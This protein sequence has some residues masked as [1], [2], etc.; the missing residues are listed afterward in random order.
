MD[1]GD[2]ESA[3]ATRRA[4]SARYKTL[5][6]DD[7]RRNREETTVSIRKEKRAEN[8][9]KKRFGGM[10]PAVDSY[11]NL[12]LQ[13]WQGANP[14][15]LVAG[16]LSD[17]PSLQLQAVTQFRKLL[18]IERSP[19]I[20]EVIAAG[21]VPRFV[22]LLQCADNPALQFEAA[23][24]LTNIASGTS[25]HTREVIS[26]GAVPIFVQLLLSSNDDV[27]EQAV[28]A[29]GNIAGDSPEC[30][31][32]VLNHGA[33]L[34]LL[35]QLNPNS[36]MSMLRNATWTLSNLCRGKPQPR[37]DF[38]SPALPKLAQL[39]FSNDEEVLADGCWALSYLSDGPNEK[40]QAVLDTGICPRIV[41]L[42]GQPHASVQTPALRTAG[43]IVTGDD[44]QTQA[45]IN[46]G[47][48]AKLLKLLSSSKKGIRKEACWTISNITAGTREQIQATI[49]A[50]VV[51]PL[52]Q[53][54]S[55]A[56]FD[57]KKEAAWSISNATSGGTPEQIAYLVKQGCIKPLCDLLTVQDARLIT[58]ALEGIENILK[59]GEQEAGSNAALG[60][61]NPYTAFVDEAEGLD[62]LEALQSHQNEDVYKKAV[63]ILET[64][65][66]I[67]DDE[68]GALAPQVDAQ[69]GFTFAQQQ[70]NAQQGGF[71]FG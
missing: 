7:A 27:R 23:W 29:L 41:E 18:S 62:K 43:N 48:L 67:E 66:G 8:V 10:P 33:L 37:W 52:V 71:Q 65:F 59:A 6:K 49:D 55:T 5:D 39:V 31:D 34:P 44:A 13:A 61:Q 64:Y 1:T 3:A 20:E 57:I 15:S 70:P 21:V 53:L 47:V 68:D 12:G 54:L 58:V 9:Q 25:D 22:Q 50:N 19:P 63:H 40:I 24:A 26:N 45:V 32:L 51:P 16:I 30:R 4:Q 38:V 69:G 35:E 14:E 2:K 36:K 28:W 60:G 56:E 11:G 46:C 17:D 42:M